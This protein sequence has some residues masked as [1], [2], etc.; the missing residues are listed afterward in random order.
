MSVAIFC[1]SDRGAELSIKLCGLLE[2]PLSRVH[3]TLKFAEKYGFTA[4]ESVRDDMGGLF[5]ANRLLIFV[6]AC[7][8]AVRSIAPH[9]K[10]KSTDPAVLVI[11]DAGR[12]V[13]SLLSGHL[14]GANGNAT[15]IAA[16]IGAVPVV[17][18]ATDNMGRFSCDAWAA[19]HNCALSGLDAAKAVSAAILEGDVAVSSEYPLPEALPAGLVRAGAGKLG[20]FI[21]IHKIEPYG[22]TL[23][24]I[25]RILCL[26]IGCRRGVSA[27]DIESA[28]RKALDRAGIDLRAV[29]KIATID[30]KRDEAGLFE[31]A[32]SLG[33]AVELYTAGELGAV[34]GEF[35]ESDFVRK[36]VGVG[37]VCERAATLGGTL[38]IPKTAANG[39]TVAAAVSDWRPEF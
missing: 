21:G 2:L 36:T 17:T 20:I 10:S 8:I 22:L 29:A 32:E 19:R 31:F 5:G 23:R 37:N 26:G 28:V 14:G 6:S 18:T 1:F 27:G 30:V 11:D 13:I 16:L 34:K 33:A 35:A 12:F 39:V 24:L 9:L 4:H 7:G 38:I 25:P 3:S 15:K